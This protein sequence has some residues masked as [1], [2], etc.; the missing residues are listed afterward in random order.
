MKSPTNHELHVRLYVAPGS[1]ASTLAR[2]NLEVAIELLQPSDAKFEIIDV[3][4]QPLRAASD[5][6]LV[7]PLLVR[8]APEP[9]RKLGGTL[10]DQKN[11]L[12]VLTG[13]A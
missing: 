4:K 8:V 6:A 5:G 1:R 10:E 3:T 7:T 9:V 2:Q 12:A 11:L 13:V